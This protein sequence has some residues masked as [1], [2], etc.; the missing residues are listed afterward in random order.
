MWFRNL[1]LRLYQWAN[2]REVGVPIGWTDAEM[3]RLYIESQGRT[4]LTQLE[5][6]GYVTVRRWVNR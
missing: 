3:D 6:V 5:R 4:R 1:T 2:P